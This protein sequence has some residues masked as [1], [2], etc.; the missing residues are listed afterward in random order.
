[1]FLTEPP[2]TTAQ[3]DVSVPVRTGSRNTYHVAHEVLHDPRGL[4]FRT[5][6]E[7]TEEIF[8]SDIWRT[9]R[10]Y[11]FCEPGLAT[12]GVLLFAGESEQ[13]KH[14]TSERVDCLDPT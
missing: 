12:V 1:M 4:I 11:R 14:E 9:T 2:V 3:L 6:M 5:I 13:D 10:R 8:Q 7:R